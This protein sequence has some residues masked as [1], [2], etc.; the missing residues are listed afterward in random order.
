MQ[1][2]SIISFFITF[3]LTLQQLNFSHIIVRREIIFEHRNLFL[4]K[5]DLGT[6]L[7]NNKQTGNELTTLAGDKS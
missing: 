5:K 1:I 7:F 6:P 2:L 3:H 4:L